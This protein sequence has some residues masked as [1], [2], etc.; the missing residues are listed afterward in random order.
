MAQLAWFMGMAMVVLQGQVPEAHGRITGSVGD[1][2]GASIP[3]ASV[4]VRTANDNK[5]L[6][7]ATTDERGNYALLVVAPGTY[8]LHF[9][10]VGFKPTIQR[11]VNVRAGVETVVPQSRL[12][13]DLDE[14]ICILTVTAEAPS[15]RHKNSRK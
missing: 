9:D 3:R 8:D 13:V 14:A 11:Q 4:L 5:T 2:A 15:K 6:A 10:A 12:F 7:T 1:P